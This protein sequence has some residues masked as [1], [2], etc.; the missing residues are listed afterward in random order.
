MSLV[1][2]LTSPGRLTKVEA[3]LRLLVAQVGFV[4]PA[5]VFLSRWVEVAVRSR[6]GKESDV[7]D[8]QRLARVVDSVAG[9]FPARTRC[10]QRSLVLLWLLRR[11][12]IGGRLRIG[13]RRNGDGVDAHAW[14]EVA[15]S[16][17]NDSPAH[18]S[19]FAVLEG[20][21]QGLAALTGVERVA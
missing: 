11:R 16:A 2:H 10:L 21:E 13:V 7:A 6:P 19:Q 12:G 18:Y 1:R 4:L 20:P 5:R 8:A 3:Y 9:R 15:R 17:V 14:V